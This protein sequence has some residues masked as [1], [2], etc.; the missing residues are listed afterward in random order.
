MKRLRAHLL[1]IVVAAAALTCGFGSHLDDALTDFRFRNVARAASGDIV[2]VAIDP[3][4]LD[5]LGVWPWPRSAHAELIRRLQDAKVR[6]I[7]FDVDFSSRSDAASDA[8]FLASLKSADGLILLPVFQ[9]P[10]GSGSLHVTRPLPQFAGNA[11]SAVVNVAAERGGLV[12]HYWPTAR[13]DGEQIPS[14]AAMLGGRQEPLRDSFLIDFGIRPE[15]VPTVSYVDILRGDPDALRR[16]S[17]KSVIVGST[18]LELGDR[19]NVPVHGVIA[20]PLLQT[21]AAEALLQRRDLHTTVVPS[22]LAALALVILML[23]LWTRTSARLRAALLVAVVLAAEAGAFAVQSWL[24]VVLETALFHIVSA[25][26]LVAAVVE[27]MNIRGLMRRVAENR[28]ARVATLVGDGLVCADADGAIRVWNASAAVIFGYEA[29]EMIGRPLDT[30]WRQMPDF[31]LSGLDPTALRRP[32]GTTVEISGHT[33]GGHP[34]PLEVCFTSWDS[35]DGIQFGAVIRD[36]SVRKREELRMRYLAEHDTLTGLINRDTLHARAAAASA[37]TTTGAEVALMILGLDE[38]HRINDM[39]GHA[40]GDAVLKAAVARLTDAAA[41][42]GQVARLAGDEFGILLAGPGAT[43]AAA[44]LAARISAAFADAPIDAANRSHRLRVSIGIATYPRD[45][46]TAEELFGCAHLALER[47]KAAAPAGTVFF[48]RTIRHAVQARLTLEAELAQALGRHE[49]ELF[50]QPQVNLVD[51]TLLGA[52]ALIRWRHPERGLLLPGDFIP[53]VNSLPLSDLVARWVIETACAQASAWERSGRPIRT[54]VN[55]SPSL[56]RSSALADVVR[57]ALG[58]TGLSPCLLELEVTED[59]L[60]GNSE[61]VL[62][63]FRQ[64]QD[65]GVRIVFD[66]F[67][68]GYA[69]LSHLRNFPLDGLKIDRTFVAGLHERSQDAAIVSCT[70]TLAQLLGMSVIAE[71]I[72]DEATA[73][74]LRTMG[75]QEGQGYLFGKP[76]PAAE[77]ESRYLRGQG[78]DGSGGLPRRDS[79]AA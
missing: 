29:E 38:F 44:N 19:F 58:R 27:E 73:L 65:L 60:L 64:V 78:A 15:T 48:D 32:G 40:C 76:M 62:Q 26:Y 39:L 23:G 10:D 59:I 56:I 16:V 25:A 52:E 68:T 57:D 36:I 75:C 71:G 14:I 12:R 24:P 6:T 33:K 79:A 5:A 18:A 1:A 3:R 55:L 35:P 2:L 47:A 30:L 37:A 9:Q 41:G 13:I 46:E 61:S 11:W 21:L 67:G 69:S 20:G 34:V 77:L 50:Y 42:C 66:D 51:G 22:A 74:L 4:S 28:F 31:S 70:V 63:A 49:F 45:C 54:A 17:G 7:A 43:E 8:A 72:E 53:V